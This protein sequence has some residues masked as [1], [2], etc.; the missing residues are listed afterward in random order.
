MQRRTFLKTGGAF[1]LAGCGTEA[2]A[3]QTPTLKSIGSVVARTCAWTSFT[4]DT[5]GNV[6]L[7]PSGHPS[8][9]I[10]VVFQAPYPSKI[11]V[12]VGTGD[13]LREADNTQSPGEGFYKI[14]SVNLVGGGFEWDVTFTPPASQ[15]VESSFRLNVANVSIKP[16]YTGNDKTSPPAVSD[17]HAARSPGSR[18]LVCGQPDDSECHYLGTVQGDSRLFVVDRTRKAVSARHFC[19]R[20]EYELFAPSRPAPQ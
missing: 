18:R 4:P 14:N 3:A 2:P 19:G 7:L 1:L 15:R 10:R 16:S 6:V 8:G 12:W 11:S 5:A 13:F 20:L 9:D 17:I